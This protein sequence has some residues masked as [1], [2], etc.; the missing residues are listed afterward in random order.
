MD[1]K[2][3][4]GPSDIDAEGERC[5]HWHHLTLRS[6]RRARLE[7]WDTSRLLPSFETPR[8]A[9]LLRMRT[10]RFFIPL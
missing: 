3:G 6:A 2:V 9:R 8:F 5:G 1:D 4:E 10:I 7:G